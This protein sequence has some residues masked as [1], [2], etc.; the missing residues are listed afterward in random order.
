VGTSAPQSTATKGVLAGPA[1][2]GDQDRCASV[3]QAGNHAEDVLNVGRGADNAVEIVFRVDALT[4]EFV[5]GD[6]ADFFGHALQQQPH[7]FDTERFFDIVVGAELH[8]VNGGFDGAM[9]RHDCDFRAWKERLGLPK[10]F[11]ARLR[12]KLQV[13]EDEIGCLLLDS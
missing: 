11:D 10:K 1:F 12:G 5:F 7:F 8:G 3:L 4:Q 9:P 2:T 13:G 6:E